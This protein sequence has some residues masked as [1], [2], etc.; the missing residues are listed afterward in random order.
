MG[1]VVEVE[2]SSE[3]AV[4]RFPRSPARV[5]ASK[6]LADQLGPDGSGGLLAALHCWRRLTRGGLQKFG[7]VYYLGTMPLP[8]DIEQ[9]Y[10][11]LV[12]IYNVVECRF[13]FHPKTGQ[14]VAME[15]FSDPDRDPC[16][17]YFH[18]YQTVGELQF[19]RRVEVRHGDGSYGVIQW[20]EP[21]LDAAPPDDK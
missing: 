8:A 2:L 17:L 7:Q 14:L 5:D 16:E 19:P 15:M 6:D 18:D 12:G 4:G 21:Q 9:H 11:V 13:F 3:V 1:G 20:Q 10:D